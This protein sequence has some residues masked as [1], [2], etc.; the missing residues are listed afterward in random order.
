MTLGAER[1]EVCGREV[2]LVDAD[3]TDP[4][5]TDECAR[6]VKFS[7]RGWPSDDAYRE[8]ARIGLVRFGGDTGFEP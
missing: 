8:C 2:V 1:C 4:V 3:D 7:G 6:T 5:P